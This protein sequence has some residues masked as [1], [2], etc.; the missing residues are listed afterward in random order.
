MGMYKKLKTK[1]AAALAAALL[2]VSAMPVYAAEE[3][4]LLLPETDEITY[5]VDSL[6]VSEEYSEEDY[7]I[8]L[9][10]AGETVEFTVI[11]DCAY[12]IEDAGDGSVFETYD[13]GGAMVSF[14]MPEEDLCLILAGETGET[15]AEEETVETEAPEQTEAAAESEVPETVAETEAAEETAAE[16]AEDSGEELPGGL[17]IILYDD[18]T[19]DATMLD[20]TVTAIE[21]NGSLWTNEEVGML[22]V[23]SPDGFAESPAV[24]VMKNGTIKG[25]DSGIIIAEGSTDEYYTIDINDELNFENDYSIR[26][27]KSEDAWKTVPQPSYNAAD[28]E[29]TEN[30]I[31]VSLKG[32]L[33]A[34][35]QMVDGSSVSL[36][37]DESY[38]SQDKIDLIDVTF[39]AG[40]Y[41]EAPDLYI[42]KDGELI[43]DN[44]D[45]ILIQ[46][47]TEV[48]YR[49]DLIN[50]IDLDST[51]E[52][53]I[54]NADTLYEEPGTEQ[55]AEPVTAEETQTES[56]S[57]AAEGS[58]DEDKMLTVIFMADSDIVEVMEVEY[59]G[60][61]SE[62]DLPEIPEKQGC[63]ASAASWDADSFENI[64]TDEIVHAVYPENDQ[65]ASS[66]SAT[67]DDDLSAAEETV[68]VY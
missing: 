38:T 46:D 29:T 51:Y 52:L 36:D 40:S 31:S 8:L 35:L 10:E 1:L 43:E 16:S 19:A 4:I 24:L 3:Y 20:D 23:Y 50:G 49:F 45:I 11:A 54:V 2:A 27:A 12:T 42:Y 56:L 37:L 58:A 68:N 28:P 39:D 48:S 13:A 57:E 30:G 5:A 53:F 55:T 61:I 62:S 34:D 18:F 17:E 7:T 44:A 47:G 32:G 60:S 66:S 67:A 15:W 41:S 22:Q 64:Q 59:A 14:E 63:D 6:H 25:E 33:C 21:E 26:V 9:Y 65:T